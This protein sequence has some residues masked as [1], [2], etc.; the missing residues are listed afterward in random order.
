MKIKIIPSFFVFIAIFICFSCKTEKDI[1]QN[2]YPTY[3]G[4]LFIAIKN[5]VDF[6]NP[7]YSND[8]NSG[9]INDLIFGALTYS[10]FNVDSGK[11]VYYPN[12]AYKWLID[13]DGKSITYYL[14]TG[15]KWSDGEK[16]SSKDVYFSYFLY[17][18]PDVMSVRQDVERFFI[19][20]KD[21]ELIPT[22]SFQIVNDSIITFNFQFKV[23]DPLFVTGLPIIPEHIFSKVPIKQIFNSELN[24]KPIGIGPFVLENYERQQQIVLRRNDS[25]FYD[26]IPFIEKLIYKVIPDYNSRINQLKNGEI[27]LIMEVRPEDA[28]VLKNNFPEIKIETIKGRDYDYIGW[29]NINQIV[30]KKSKGKIIKPHPLFGDKEIRYALTLAINRKEI[31]EGYFGEFATLAE[32]PISPI[33]KSY[34]NYNLKPIP[35]NPEEAKKILEKKGWKDTNGDGIIDKNGQ[36]FKFKLNIATGK[37]HREFA[38][39]IVKRDLKKI[40]IEVEI[41]VLETSVFFSKMFERE[42]DAWIAGWTIPLDLDLEAFWGSNLEKNFFNVCSYQNPEIDKIFL[43]LKNVKSEKEKIELIQSFQKIIQ[44]DQPVTFLYWIDNII[45]YNRKLKNVKFNPIAYTNR[46]WEWFVSK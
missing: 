34:I 17:T 37:P 45:A 27:D 24:F 29:N 15:L 13:K 10:D 8:I 2:I 46:I 31:L 41:E 1:Q 35:F 42:L 19:H 7:L 25:S 23:D 14:K 9:L 16:F 33:F 4:R 6:F 20:N 5:D 11:L 30:Y 38:A 39:T 32:T 21:G 22:K 36:P 44:E 28:E 3:G 18:H 26:K 12:L 43:D 40:G